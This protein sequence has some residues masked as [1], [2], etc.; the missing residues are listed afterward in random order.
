MDRSRSS[1][2][3]SLATLANYAAFYSLLSRWVNRQSE[4]AKNFKTP[5]PEGAN[6][7]SPGADRGPGKPDVGL[8]GREALGK[9]CCNK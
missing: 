2:I 9:L 5:A 6:E 3:G 7:S 4:R 8:L 1:D